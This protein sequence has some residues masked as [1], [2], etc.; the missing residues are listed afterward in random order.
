[1][2]LV[3][4]AS[5][6]ALLELSSDHVTSRLNQLIIQD[7]PTPKRQILQVSD[8]LHGSQPSLD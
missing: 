6:F 8:D 3:F 2:F 7:S 4:P 5:R 1:M